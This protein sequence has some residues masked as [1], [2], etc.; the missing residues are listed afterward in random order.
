VE[1][2]A[3]SSTSVP[4][5]RYI[6][7][8]RL[9]QGGMGEVFRAI[10]V[11]EAG[12]EKPVVVK[13]ILPA[14]AG[15]SDFADLFVA[16][17]KLMTRLAHP[18][19]VEVL[20]FGR[21]AGGEAFLVLELVHGLDLGCLSRAYASRGEPFP[22]PLAL[23]ITAQILRGLHHAHARSE[24]G[25]W[26]VHRDV[27][28]GNVLLSTE[29]E[30]KVADFGVALSQ[31]APLP[32][33][34]PGDPAG[35]VGLVGKPGYMA[36]EQFGGRDLDPRADLF[37]V[38]VVLFELLTHQLPFVGKTFVEQQ[39]SAHRGDLLDLRGIREDVPDAV[40]AILR[41]ALAPRREDRFPDAKAMAQ[42]IEGLRDAGVRVAGSDDVADTVRAA[43]PEKPAGQL[44]IA[45]SAEEEP[46]QELTR[47]GETGGVG[48]FTLRVTDRRTLRIEEP[49]PAPVHG[50]VRPLLSLRMIGFA[51][52]GLIL[53]IVVGLNF[54]TRNARRHV[55]PLPS[56]EL[57]APTVSTVD[58]MPRL[59]PSLP[60]APTAPPP[61]APAPQRP[62][63]APSAATPS[64]APPAPSAPPEGCEGIVRITSLGSWTVS[65]GPRTVQ[66][67]GLYTWKC[68]TFSLVA[69]SRA[70][71]RQIK[72][73]EV[74]IHAGATSLVDLR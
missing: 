38:G 70:D 6:L 15:R 57:P 49:A 36:P 19:I 60:V 7:K 32:G 28:P 53:L 45:L 35:P 67:P 39:A 3:P 5:G 10:A 56:A 44:V 69:V 55:A 17:A 47:T 37:S 1:R 33:V 24:G 51:V 4:F 68:G 20:D 43:M 14:H 34:R 73:A 42:A 13:R 63:T 18:N 40:D 9:A 21:G 29:G 2:P 25:G 31:R 16:E 46:E 59:T 62:T 50:H 8:E 58:P 26:L 11:G 72:R 74:T 48:A 61:I 27:S 65:G 64:A 66:S 52:V 30:V 12:F 23:F 71:P 22:L 54:R 41:R